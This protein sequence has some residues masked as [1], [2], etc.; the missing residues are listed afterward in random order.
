LVFTINLCRIGL[1]D[2]CDWLKKLDA[3]K[4]QS[5][6]KRITLDMRVGFLLKVVLACTLSIGRAANE[7]ILNLNTLA[8]ST[9]DFPKS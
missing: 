7:N 3:N 9:K 6:N 4:E 5:I 1:T 2:S 8:F